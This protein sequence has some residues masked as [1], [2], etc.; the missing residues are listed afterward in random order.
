[1]KALLHAYGD[2]GLRLVEVPKSSLGEYPEI[3]GELAERP[4]RFILAE[5][6]RA[7]AD[8]E[9]LQL[10]PDGSMRFRFAAEDRDGL[11]TG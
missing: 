3:V 8:G 2:R 4:E 9:V 1:M 7:D 5:D 6:L 10:R 11:I